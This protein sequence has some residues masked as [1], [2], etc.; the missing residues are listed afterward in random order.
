MV[1]KK[2]T[3]IVKDVLDNEI[4]FVK[5]DIDNGIPRFKI[6]TTS[7]RTI[8]NLVL[9]NKNDTNSAPDRLGFKL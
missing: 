9:R 3:E 7:D 8:S 6:V 4:F 5:L 2:L 1:S